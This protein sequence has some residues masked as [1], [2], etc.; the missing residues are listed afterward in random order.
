MIGTL[1]TVNVTGEINHDDNVEMVCE[2]GIIKVIDDHGGILCYAEVSPSDYS[3]K[4]DEI[5]LVFQRNKF[6]STWIFKIKE[7]NQT[8]REPIPIEDIECKQHGTQP[9]KW[10]TLD[11]NIICS[12]CFQERFEKLKGPIMDA[13]RDKQIEDLNDRLEEGDFSD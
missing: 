7:L 4:N 9:G 8:L 13:L 5:V 6:K 10:I 3:F 2:E 1:T 12:V 11:R